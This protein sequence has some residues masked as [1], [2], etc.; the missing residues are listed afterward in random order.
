MIKSKIL[1]VPDKW[2]DY[3]NVQKN[4]IFFDNLD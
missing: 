3:R 1:I 4:D 2:N